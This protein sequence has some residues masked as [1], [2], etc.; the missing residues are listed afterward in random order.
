MPSDHLYAPTAASTPVRPH[1]TRSDGGFAAARA[2]AD[3]VEAVQRTRAALTVAGHSLD[4][5][6]CVELLSMLG[7]PDPDTRFGGV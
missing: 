6:D 7:L 4:P 2:A 5:R 3:E 1:R